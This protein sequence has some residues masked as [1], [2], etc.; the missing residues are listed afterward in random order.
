MTITSSEIQPANV[1]VTF[2]D[3]IAAPGRAL[4]RISLYSRRSWWLPA[5]LA[6]CGAVL[7]LAVTLEQ[8]TEEARRQI[9]IQLS[10]MTSE[11]IE[12]ARPTMDRFSEPNAILMMG[13]VTI[14]L[15]LVVAWLISVMIVYLG[16]SVSGSTPKLNA[17]WPAVV[18]TWLP[19]AFR[20]L[21]QA[22]WGGINGTIVRYPGLSYLLATGDTAADQLAPLYL[23]ASQIDL[24]ALWHVVLIFVLLRS[25]TKL[26][27]GSS[28]IITILYSAIN[29]GLRLIPALLGSAFTPS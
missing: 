5:L 28:L 21:L 11:Q 7:N 13:V 18:W 26:G 16:A 1:F 2:V 9:E 27:M 25:V 4:Q 3:M 15:G 14:A 20:E 12:A 29:I 8:R 10:S 24:F 6:F 22:V 17:L 23:A 19:L